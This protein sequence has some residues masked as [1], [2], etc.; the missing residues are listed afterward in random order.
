[1]SADATA[2][3]IGDVGH[4]EGAVAERVERARRQ[5]PF[6]ADRHAG[7][8]SVALADQPTCTKADLAGYGRF[9]LSARPLS[10]M[11]HVAATS[12]T[13]GAR[14]FVGFTES[15][16]SDVRSQYRHVVG[17][18]GLGRGDVLL[19]THGAG[20]WIGA[21]SLQE[22]AHAAGAGTIPAGPTNPRQVLEWLAELPVTLL[23]ATP[24]YLRV[25]VETA[26]AEGVH[27][28]GVAL[29]M[30]LLGGEGASRELR[31]QVATAFG[32]EFRW[33]ELYGS[34]ETAGPILAFGDTTDP[35][36]GCLEVNTAYFVV[37]ILELD[38]DVPV[39]PGEVGELTLT[40]P[41][42]EGSP[43]VRY[44][45]RDLA[46]ALPGRRGNASGL[47]MI[48]S[49][50]GRVDDAI[51][52]RG[53]LVYPRMIEEACVAG[54]APGAEWRIVVGRRSAEHDTMTVR[55]ETDDR[56]VLAD[57]AERIHQATR[58]RPVLEAVP[59]GSLERFPGKA[60]RVV[61]E[62]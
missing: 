54:L 42:R 17:A 14:L 47:P 3:D 4:H 28:H 35:L 53:A 49:V 13:T 5:V 15:D 1:M 56:A 55:V 41:Y 23:S 11:F 19:N 29:R 46:A 61:D 18:A 37:E 51:K 58:V 50:L 40:T 9:P 33:Q 39:A 22:L 62:R 48:T 36:S 44:R 52:V 25:L 21:P 8:V 38:H 32:P 20:L 45:T 12:G 7:L 30:G 59:P 26:A 31:A 2:P 34:T 24:S 6:Y 16:W 60:A 10:E 43:L 57:L 27:L